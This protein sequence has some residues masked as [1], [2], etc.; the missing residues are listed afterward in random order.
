M[1]LN[2]FVDMGQVTK[3]I[4]TANTSIPPSE[5]ATD[6]FNYGAEKLHT[7]YG[8]GLRLVMNY[9]FVMAIDYGIA[10]NSQDGDSGIYIGLNYLF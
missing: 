10:T 5:I 1:G 3:K 7:S 6:Y 2:T 9:N 4:K 8:A